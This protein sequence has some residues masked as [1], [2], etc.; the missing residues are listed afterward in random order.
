MTTLR[1]IRFAF[2]SGA[3]DYAAIY[4]WRSWLLGWYLRVLTQV[5]FFAL[6]GTLLRSTEQ[7]WYLLVGNAIMLAAMQGIFALGLVGQERDAGTLPLLVASPSSP[8]VV[9]AAR[10]SYLIADGLVSAL[11]A[12]FVAGALFGLPLPFPRVLLV[13]P[14][15]LIIGVSAYCFAAFLAGV[16]IRSRKLGG[17]VANVGTVVFMTLCGVNVPLSAYPEPV[18]F[19][20]RFLPLT[21]GLI[22][23]RDVLAGRTGAALAQ[24]GLEALV[25]LGWLLLCLATFGRF[26]RHGRRDGSLDFAS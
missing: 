25:G 20:A 11:G 16:L 13:V 18:A 3:K 22:G 26:I 8:V 19:V 21:H 23:I 4:T 24:I 7:T 10:G 12:L 17:L 5:I 15:T 2:L 9:F 14:L 6:I 1:I